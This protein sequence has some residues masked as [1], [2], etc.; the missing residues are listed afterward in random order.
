M[1]PP[2]T[3]TQDLLEQLTYHWDGFVRP[4]LAGLTDDEYHWEPVAGCWGVHPQPDGT[5]TVDFTF[6][7]PDPPPVT[8][9]AWRLG[10]VIVGIFGERNHSHFG[11]P[12]IDYQHHAWAATAD[13]ALAQLDDGYRRWVD[14]VAGLDDA[15][16][17]R[18]VGEAEGP[19]A[20]FP[21]STLVLHIHREVIHHGAE[22]LLLRDLYR[23]R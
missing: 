21:Y 12:P 15:G 17:A 23:N 2:A 5:A 8:T 10:H 22:V 11:G 3:R 1:Q 20:A 16:L 6:P 13:E 4:K 9:I 14:G 7:E 18:P 19:F